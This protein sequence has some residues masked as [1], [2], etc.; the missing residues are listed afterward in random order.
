MCLNSK[1]PDKKIKPFAIANLN[2]GLP[3]TRTLFTTLFASAFIQLGCTW[4]PLSHLGEKV[5]VLEPYEINSCVKK[6]KATV[7]VRHKVAGIERDKKTITK[8]LERLARNA[9]PDLAGDTVV[10]A[11]PVKMGRQT[12]HIYKC[13]DPQK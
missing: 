10:A 3:M 6:G 11:S 7:S 13:V 4:A 12:F 5:R 9:A 8:E 1:K 2:P